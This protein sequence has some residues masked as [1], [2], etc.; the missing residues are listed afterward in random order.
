MI[1]NVVFDIG[2]VLAGFVWKDFYESFG[3]S[4][5][6]NEK[7][8][9]ATVRSA[10][11][12]ELDRGKMTDEELLAGF[13]AND[14][15]IEKEICTVFE[16]IT[17]MISR[18]DYAIPWLKDLKGRGYSVY[19]ISNFSH[20]AHVQCTAALDFLQEMQG[21]ILSYQERVIKPSPEIYQL[22][23]TR[24]GL[25]AKEC[26]FIDDTQVNVEAAQQ[27]GMK[28][29]VFHTLEQAK[30]DLEQ[31]LTADGEAYCGNPLREPV[32]RRE[33]PVHIYS[34]YGEEIPVGQ[35]SQHLQL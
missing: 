31:I 27:E 16:N 17:D 6:I 15:S 3:F 19:Y 25:K 22:F 29:I 1:K 26:V 14:P 32:Y 9:N 23:L 11:W 10:L 34:R 24:Y 13:I 21:G 35:E 5:E 8:A 2:N 7:L 20:R 4:Q 30:T 12:N 28:G 18:Y 33:S